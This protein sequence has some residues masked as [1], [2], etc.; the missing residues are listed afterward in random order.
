MRDEHDC[1]VLVVGAGPTG[2][3]AALVLAQQGV[4]VRIVDRKAGPVEQAR[5]AI[6]HARTLEYLD[7]LGVADAAVARGRLITNVA[8]HEGG[9]HAGDM[10]LAGKG[11]TD[12]TRFPYALALEQFETERLLAEALAEHEVA[13][14]WNC[15]VRDLTDTG[16]GVR[17]QLAAEAGPTTITARW[18]VGADGAS[19]TI[20]RILGQEFEGETYE[21]AG[22]LA[23]VTLDV[24]LGVQ[25]MRLSLTRGG[26]VGILPLAS[27]RCRLFGVVPPELHQAPAQR[28]GPS[29]ES[30]APL[31]HADLQRW[32][33]D[34]FTVDANLREVSWASMFRFHSRLAARFRVG[35]AFLV[36]DAAHIHNPAGGQGL[37]L[38]IG[39]AV[40]LAWKL[41]QVV[42]GE[43]PEWLLDTYESERRPIA[44][45]VLKRT[46]VGFKLETTDNPVATWM[47]ANVATRVVG[48]VSRLAPVRRLVFH[49]FSQLWINYRGSRAV[50]PGVGALKP[51]DRAPFAPIESTRDGARS[52]LDL[53]HGAGYHLLVF[54]ADNT[55]TDELASQLTARYHASVTTHVIPAGEHAAYRAYQVDGPRLVLV[56]PDGHIA[57]LAAPSS[58]DP[59]I[60]YLDTVLTKARVPR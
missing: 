31:A 1:D 4:R 50:G 17:V 3:C 9:R 42:N 40:N 32:F 48:V 35:N 20:R 55:D 36:G 60:T 53:T 27:G 2:L 18:L 45:T 13:V 16:D 26:F 49:M 39:D 37:N 29:H 6:V 11:T 14:G 59:L 58:V 44:E 25:G 30:Y 33:D 8:I 22:M 43:A 41:A 34:Y 23:D 21:Q 12:Q 56:R 15:E 52:V 19:S 5:A 54:S 10:P 46:D 24:E 38:G 28:G 51:G 47:R 7:R 57:A